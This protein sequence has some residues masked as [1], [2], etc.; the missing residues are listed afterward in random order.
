MRARDASK[1]SFASGDIRG[2][3]LDPK[4]MPSGAEP[5]PGLSPPD[6]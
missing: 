3:L 2:H 6:A 5:P 4:K 1:K